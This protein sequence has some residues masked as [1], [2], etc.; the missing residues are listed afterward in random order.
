MSGSAVAAILRC[1]ATEDK[2][3]GLYLTLYP[4]ALPMF[5]LYP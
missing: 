4:R 5:G 3:Q 2:R 1:S